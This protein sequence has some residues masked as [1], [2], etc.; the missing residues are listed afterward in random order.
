METHSQSP[1]SRYSFLRGFSSYFKRLLN[2]QCRTQL[3]AWR[4]FRCNCF[5]DAL[6]LHLLFISKW[7]YV[8]QDMGM[9]CRLL[10]T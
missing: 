10:F 9:I 2:E 5:L 1:G 7:S 8:G 4:T 3:S 6:P